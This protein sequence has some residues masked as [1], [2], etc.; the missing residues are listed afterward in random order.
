MGPNG[1]GK[2]TLL[3]MIS[4]FYRPDAGSIELG[5]VEVVGRSP[6]RIARLYVGRTFQTPKLCPSCRRSRT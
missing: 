2:T 4:G 3:N 6:A 5:G 1:S